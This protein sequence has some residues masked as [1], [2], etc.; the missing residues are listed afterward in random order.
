VKFHCSPRCIQGA[1]FCAILLLIF[2]CERLATSPEMARRPLQPPGLA[3][4]LVDPDCTDDTCDDQYDYWGDDGG[5]D[6]WDSFPDNGNTDA[7]EFNDTHDDLGGCDVGVNCT[8]RVPSS[9]E[10]SM[11]TD[12][13]STLNNNS[14]TFCQQIGS[15]LGSMRSD[16]L[17][18]FFDNHITVPSSQ[19]SGY[20]AGDAHPPNKTGD[21]YAGQMHIY[22]NSR[23]ASSIKHTLAHEAAHFWGLPDGAPTGASSPFNMTADEAASYCIGY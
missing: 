3:F 10:T 14:S 16:S 13:A 19:G 20:L 18:K 9:A 8:L 1:A 23:S 2:G 12:V 11:I 4:L 7:S 5:T 17:I 6:T 22:G 15:I 21:P